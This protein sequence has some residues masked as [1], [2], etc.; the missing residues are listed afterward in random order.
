MLHLCKR[1]GYTTTKLSSFKDHINRKNICKPLLSMIPVDNI[2]TRQCLD[3]ENV[4][5]MVNNS[6]NHSDEY[7][8]NVTQRTSRN[9]NVLACNNCGKVF[10]H[11]SSKCKHKSKG[12]CF[13]NELQVMKAQLA[14]QS[15]QIAAQ[16][17]KIA[18]LENRPTSTINN[19]TI[20]TK[21]TN[22]PRINIHINGFGKEDLRHITQPVISS[23]I[24]NVY[25]STPALIKAIHFDPKHPENHNIKYP[26]KRGKYVMLAKGDGTW[27]HVTKREA[28]DWLIETNHTRLEDAL[29][30]AELT[31]TAR[32]CFERYSAK[33]RDEDPSTVRDVRGRVE[34]A[35]LDNRKVEEVQSSI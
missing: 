10:K 31:K 23:C 14:M 21:I 15:G 18:D 24:G 27:Q 3:N 7:L 29:P 8:S 17:A 5:Q 34:S 16:A 12:I 25:D 22:K 26:N 11:R 19:T 2:C 4:S 32:E 1:C 20:K 33:I 30:D 9:D 6:I 35:L 28:I 13:T